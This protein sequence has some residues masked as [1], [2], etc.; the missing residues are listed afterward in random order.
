MRQSAIVNRFKTVFLTIPGVD[1]A[2]LY[3][4]LA[5]NEATPNSDIDIQMVVNNNFEDNSLNKAIND[6]F[7]EDILTIHKV[8][9]RNKIVVYLKQLPKIEIAICNSFEDIVR[10]YSGSE[11]ENVG[12][13]IL[14]ERA[15]ETSH[16]EQFLGTLAVSNHSNSIDQQVSELIDKFIYEFESCSNM[17]RRSDGYQFYYFYN[18]ALHVTTQLRHIKNGHRRFIFLPKYFLS[19]SINSNE[20]NLF[21]ELNGSIFL[22]DANQKKR[23][24]LD[25]FYESI[26]GLVDN[27]KYNEIKIL[28]E[29]FYQRDFFWNFRDIST[30]NS[31]IKPNV[32]YRTATMSVFQNEKQFEELLS[33]KNIKTVIDLRANR[34][35]EE[36]PYSEETLVKFKYVKAQ[37][38][39]WNQPE[40]FVKDHHYGTN[41]EIAYRF[42]TIGCRNKI[43]SAFEAIINER[44]GA[45]AIHC[46]AGKDRTGILIS[47]IHLLV[48]TPMEVLETDY[49]ASE[50]D[51]K[52]YRLKMVLDIIE[53][54]GGIH[55]YLTNCGLTTEQLVQLR[56]KL[57]SHEYN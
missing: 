20:Q 4:S 1:A 19:N 14:F 3:G 28:C 36:K 37:L 27:K 25:F 13:T 22:P 33:V 35:I 41:E 40:W 57:I 9:L 38:D 50:V 48:D 11:I 12:Q 32:I 47:M 23:K 34:E 43:K 7:S 39:P 29:C 24:L 17:H 18:I 16:L 56:E 6:E 8:E 51:V 30:H 53:N 42:F 15:P 49:L 45:V 52:L 26:N 55:L 46:F 21:Y 44:K 5:R 2:I 10:N 31:R 54:E